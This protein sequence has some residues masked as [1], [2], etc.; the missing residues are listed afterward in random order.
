MADPNT[1]LSGPVQGNRG[2]FNIQ[3]GRFRLGDE[4]P[5]HSRPDT[6]QHE[7]PDQPAHAH[8]NDAKGPQEQQETYQNDD[9]S[10]D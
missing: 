6:Y 7:R 2:F 9:Q 1:R 10:Q 8:T 4:V 5:E 3:W